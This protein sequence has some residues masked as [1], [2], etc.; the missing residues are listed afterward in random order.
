MTQTGQLWS[1]E[2][3]NRPRVSFR[4]VN[5]KGE[6]GHDPGLQRHHLLPRQS[7]QRDCFSRLWEAVGHERIGFNDFRRNGI[8]LPAAEGAALR[9]GLPLHRGPHRDY[10]QLVIERIGQIER[11]WSEERFRAPEAAL[12]QARMRLVL[13]QRALRRSLLDDRRRFRLNRKCPLGTGYDFRELDAMAETLW[14]GTQEGVRPAL[15]PS[16]IFA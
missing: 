2:A 4:S 10:N 13:L 7:L 15:A 9:L 1:P 12:E 11:G 16:S 5:R 3:P 6:P 14:L 8:L